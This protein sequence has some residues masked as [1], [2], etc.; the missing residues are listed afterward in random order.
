MIFG[1]VEVKQSRMVITDIDPLAKSPPNDIVVTTMDAAEHVVSRPADL[2]AS[3]ASAI[4]NG[5]AQAR[6]S[7]LMRRITDYRREN[8]AKDILAELANA[9]SLSQD[10]LSKLVS[11][12]VRN[13]SQRVMK[14]ML[15]FANGFA[16][17]ANSALEKQIASR[18]EQAI[19]LDPAAPSG[20]TPEATQSL[21]VVSGALTSQIIE[22]FK[23]G[24]LDQNRVEMLIE[25][26]PG[27]A[28]AGK[29]LFD[30]LFPEV[31]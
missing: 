23:G 17:Q 4:G 13:Q 22:D 28:L 5:Q 20:L 30:M 12:I 27:S 10:D 31:A 14:L 16:Q 1:N 3:L 15:F 25:G 6:V 2:K 9:D 19:A 11:S 7:E 21:A 8:A 24:K 18:F 29:V 26:G